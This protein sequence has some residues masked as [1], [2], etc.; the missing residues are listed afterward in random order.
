MVSNIRRC[1]FSSPI[2]FEWVICFFKD[3]ELDRRS[4][5][6]YWPIHFLIWTTTAVVHFWIIKSVETKKMT[7]MSCFCPYLSFPS[8]FF[9]QNWM[10]SR[11]FNFNFLIY[12]RFQNKKVSKWPWKD[13]KI[14]RQYIIIVLLKSYGWYQI[15]RH[16]IGHLFCTIT[17]NPRYVHLCVLRIIAISVKSICPPKSSQFLFYFQ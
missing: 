10:K 16:C 1:L 15:S 9:F 6:Y 17:V 12:V 7:K 11:S 14:K 4:W 2:S 5:K 8:F 3:Q 13:Y